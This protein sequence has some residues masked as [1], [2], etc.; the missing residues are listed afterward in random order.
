MEMKQKYSGNRP[1][2]FV[3]YIGFKAADHIVQTLVLPNG[4]TRIDAGILH[5][6]QESEDQVTLFRA[7]GN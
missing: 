6:M 3:R 5:V 7:E 2:M 1:S 4:G